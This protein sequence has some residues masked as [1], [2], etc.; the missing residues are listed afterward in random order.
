MGS[1]PANAPAAAPGKRAADTPENGGTSP[2]VTSDTLHVGDTVTEALLGRLIKLEKFEHKLAEVARVYRNLNAARKAVEVVLKKLT[3]VQSIADVEELEEFLSNLNVKSQYAG[4]QIGALTELD[5][6]N[7]AKIHELETKSAN[8]AAAD[9][10]RDRLVRELETMGKERKVVEGQL[11]RSN[12]KLK[13]DIN[14]LE[15]RV[16][17]LTKENSTLKETQSADS[18]NNSNPDM[19]ADRLSDL[20]TARHPVSGGKVGDEE[21]V[22][23]TSQSLTILQQA[24]V[25]R[26]GIPKGLVAASE[27]QDTVQAHESA[28]QEAAQAKAIMRKELA[29]CVE[30]LKT[31]TTEKDAE[32]AKV[33]EQLHEQEQRTIAEKTELEDKVQK[34]RSIS[35]AKTAKQDRKSDKSSGELTSERVAEIIYAAVA[36]KLSLTGASKD[37]KSQTSSPPAQKPATAGGKKKGGKNKRRGT[38]S[39]GGGTKSASASP[40]A[41]LPAQIAK[42]AKTTSAAQSPALVANNLEPTTTTADKGEVSRLIELIETVASDGASNKSSGDTSALNLQIKE[43]RATADD[44]RAQLDVARQTV[45]A[46]KAKNAE[47]VDALRAEIAHLE[48]RLSA[49][50]AERVRLSEEVDVLNNK[51]MEAETGLQ[52]SVSSSEQQIKDLSAELAATKQQSTEESQALQTQVKAAESRAAT[53]ETE[54]DECRGNLL[55]V[56]AQLART[57]QEADELRKMSSTFKDERSRLAASLAKAQGAG[58]RQEA[59]QRELQE[60]I[61]SLEA[62]CAAEKRQA[63]G[64]QEA[65]DR[66]TAEHTQAQSA[67]EAR[68]QSASELEQ[69]LGEAQAK[70]TELEEHAR[71]VDADLASSRERFAEKSRQLAQATAQLQE[72]QYTLEKER[73][74]ATAAADGA[75]K[76]LA[77]TCEQLAEERRATQEQGSD[78]RKEIERLQ[79][80]LGD[81]DKR[82]VQAGQLER[83]EAQ[84]AEKELELETMRSSLQQTEESRT[85]LQVEADRLRDMERDLASAKEQLE[86]VA[87]ERRLSE[88]RWKRVHRDL[89]EEVRRLHR[90]RQSSVSSANLQPLS[91]GAAPSAAAS[92]S[93]NGFGASTSSLSPSGR[94]NSMTAASVSSLLRAATGNAATTTTG[95]G[96]SA[97]RTSVQS[98]SSLPVSRATSGPGGS[99]KQDYGHESRT[100]ESASGPLAAAAAGRPRSHTR[101]EHS[102]NHHTRSSS[103][104]GSVSSEALSYDEGRFEAINVEYLRNVLFRFFNDKERRSQLVPV[105]SNLLNCKVDDIKQIQ[106]LLQ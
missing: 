40:A 92:G 69:K 90:E 37:D 3:P 85:A 23:T 16:Q 106:L 89:K 83:L 97:R 2:S 32:L 54:I 63:G 70:V 88:Q 30:R 72:M 5:K 1:E 35:D 27:L 29:E 4:E 39:T 52:D 61:S 24:L 46:S 47:Q 82:A 59:R 14:E 45:E 73:R 57:R 105:L 93:G 96:F 10:D 49:A 38:V 53:L 86:R 67:L 43:L 78:S 11:E 94:S 25:D 17:E 41:D 7:R 13:L 68:A 91:P 31:I 77:A 18:S 48:E 19:L 95:L 103:N 60:R 84:C 87:D 76:E 28:E 66:L 58:A 6:A 20:L 36:R 34:A 8:L 75:A 79:R 98:H 74:A 44:L 26:C 71:A 12:Q 21:K 50:E 33:R 81:L 15:A 42:N 22:S 9:R 51:L 65:L 56:E 99:G 102:S 64:V 55:D 101:S 100:V 62:E 80:Q 104:A